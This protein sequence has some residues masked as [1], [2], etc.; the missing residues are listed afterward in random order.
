MTDKNFE[1]YKPVI[2][3]L[4]DLP[5]PMRDIILK[6]PEEEQ[7]KAAK[8][9]LAEITEIYVESY[10]GPLPPP[11]VLVEYDKIVPGSAKLFIDS[12]HN[13]TNSRINNED[14]VTKSN[15][16]LAKNGQIMAFILTIFILLLASSFQFMG[17]TTFAVTLSSTTIIAL[18][19]VF[20]TG[21]YYK[22]KESLSD[23]LEE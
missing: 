19:T 9:L 4:I 3:R 17:F 5:Q 2:D 1:P 10:S 12:L 8:T 20:I 13:Q 7:E 22:Q 14:I 6:L 11:S 18:V 15:V 16:S 21:R 23:D